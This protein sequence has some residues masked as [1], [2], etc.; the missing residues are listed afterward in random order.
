M[1]ALPVWALWLTLAVMMIGLVGAIVPGIPGV[2]LIWAAALVYGL[3]G[4]FVTFSPWAFAA[5]TMRCDL[6]KEPTL[7]T[8]AKALGAAAGIGCKVAP[9][10]P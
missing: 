2:I 10:I 6:T 1:T 4:G 7:K 8:R 5:L 9:N 3:A